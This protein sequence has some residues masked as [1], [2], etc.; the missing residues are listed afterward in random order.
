MGFNSGIVAPAGAAGVTAPTLEVG[1]TLSSS[2]TQL[3]SDTFSHTK[4]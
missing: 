4:T 2:S 3:M 1:L